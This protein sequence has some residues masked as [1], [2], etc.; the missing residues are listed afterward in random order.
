MTLQH[1]DYLHDIYTWM[2]KAYMF[3]D[4][5]DLNIFIGLYIGTNSIKVIL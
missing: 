5:Q 1:L 3:W 2:V 4:R